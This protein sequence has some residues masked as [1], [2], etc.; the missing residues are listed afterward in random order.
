MHWTYCRSCLVSLSI[1]GIWISILAQHNHPTS[2]FANQPFFFFSVGPSFTYVDGHARDFTG[3]LY[4]F[5]LRFHRRLA[6]G[7]TVGIRTTVN[8][9][10][11]I[12]HFPLDPVATDDSFVYNG[13]GLKEPMNIR[14]EYYEGGLEISRFIGQRTTGASTWFIRPRVG[15]GYGMY[16]YTFDHPGYVPILSGA[17]RKGFDYLHGGFILYEGI[18]IG[19]LSEYNRLHLE[20][21][22]EARQ[23]HSKFLRKR[24]YDRP[25]ISFHTVWDFFISGGALMYV[26]IS[27]P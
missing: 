4:G 12:R 24:A 23:M 3:S 13:L 2:R 27:P 5:A 14:F 25:E 16:R 20:L 15:I 22:I 8:L 26:L 1:G 21:I 9:T 19:R 17:S 10:E 18:G 11:K 7:W 6:T